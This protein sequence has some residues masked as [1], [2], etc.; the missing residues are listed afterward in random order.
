M[1]WDAARQALSCDHRTPKPSDRPVAGARTGVEMVPCQAV[2]LASTATVAR[3]KAR[4]N[5]WETGTATGDRCGQ[6]RVTRP[7]RRWAP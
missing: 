5:G 4:A 1:S 6:H 2:A 7:R 3:S